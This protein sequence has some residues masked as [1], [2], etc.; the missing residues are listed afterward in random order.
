MIDRGK[1][2]ALCSYIRALIK[3]KF[4]CG[5]TD[6][7]SNINGQTLSN[8]QIS[9]FIQDFPTTRSLMI[10][11]NCK[12]LQ[13]MQSPAGGVIKGVDLFVSTQQ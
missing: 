11:R 4:Q 10:A 6:Q 1:L 13:G 12:S 8:Y 7:V 9:M 2:F 3:A 5:Q